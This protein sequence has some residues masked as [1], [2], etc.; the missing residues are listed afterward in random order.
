MQ[1]RHYVSRTICCLALAGQAVAESN[2]PLFAS[3][4][5][6]DVTFVVPIETVVDDAERRPVVEGYMEYTNDAGQTVRLDLEMN[7]RGHSRLEYCRFPPLKI[8]LKRKQ[9]ED[10]LFDGQ[11]KLKVVTHCRGGDTFERYLLQEYSIYDAFNVIA[12]RSFRVRPLRVTYRDSEGD[13]DDQVHPAFFIETD[14]EVADRYDMEEVAVSQIDPAQLEPRHAIKHALFQ[15]L[16]G[17]TDWSAIRGPADD[18]CCHNTK[19]LAPPGQQDKWISLPYDFDQAGIINT[20]YSAP[21][22]ELGIRSVRQRVY[23]GRCEHHDYLDEVIAIFN[24]RRSTLEAALLP[25]GLEGRTRNSAERYI[26]QFYEII[27]DPETLRREITD[28]CIG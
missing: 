1:V 24:D 3:D 5:T 13:E 14:H 19:P 7:T 20:R 21:A 11:N 22:S 6:L 23:R 27:N 17:N 12:E 2:L 9:A 16:I 8:D 25:D 10:T 26:N 18:N 4:E 28:Q 15:Y